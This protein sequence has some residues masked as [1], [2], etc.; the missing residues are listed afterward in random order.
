MLH[1]LNPIR[2]ALAA[3]LMLASLALLL[4]DGGTARAQAADK[5]DVNDLSMEVAALQTIH[6]LKLSAGQLQQLA[7]MAKVTAGKPQSRQ[8][9]DVSEKYRRTLV[10]LH[11]ALSK[12]EDE[13]I[14]SLGEHLQELRKAEDP[15]LDDDIGITDEARRQAPRVLALLSA[16]QVVNHL[17]G[18]GDE[19]P[20]PNRLMFRTMRLDGKGRRPSAAQWKEVRDEVARDVGM[21]LGGVDV[22]QARKLSEQA[23]K[24]LDKAY[25]ISKPEEMKKR[26]PE[27]EKELRALVGGVGPMDVLRHIMENDLA[28]LLSNPR[29]AAAINARMP[30]PK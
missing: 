28:E 23:A 22:A 19:V 3:G 2:L 1:A 17:A 9:A 12:R 8:A 14:A 16:P 27:L 18:Y 15:D 21:L 24:L 30:K 20:H 6:H 10:E 7:G 5:L 13:P 11:G 4:S 26:R 29:L 25:A